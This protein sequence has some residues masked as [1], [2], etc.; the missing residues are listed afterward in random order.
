MVTLATHIT[1]STKINVIVVVAKKPKINIYILHLVHT[2][3]SN[4]KFLMTS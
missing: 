1:M 3:T 4:V 2:E